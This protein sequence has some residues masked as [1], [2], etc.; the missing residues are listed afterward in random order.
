MTAALRA[1]NGEKGHL[2]Y[3][4]RCELPACPR[5]GLAAALT[6]TT[7]GPRG[8]VLGGCPGCSSAIPVKQRS[9]GQTTVGGRCQRLTHRHSPV[10]SGRSSGLP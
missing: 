2:R 8:P 9:T 1:K 7:D 5:Q 10:L 3:P 6:P 4:L